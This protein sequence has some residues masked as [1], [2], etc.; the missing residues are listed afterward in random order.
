MA[1]N[2]NKLTEGEYKYFLNTVSYIKDVLNIEIEIG[3]ADHTKIKGHEKA[4]G[5]AYSTTGRA[6]DMFKI[7]IDI[8]FIKFCYELNFVFNVEDRELEETI[9]HEIAHMKQFRHT[10]KHQE[11]TNKYIRFVNWMKKL[12]KIA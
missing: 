3:I 11:L 6:K 9:C 1:Y 10:K 2:N 4:V 8:D 12:D 7:T 5:L